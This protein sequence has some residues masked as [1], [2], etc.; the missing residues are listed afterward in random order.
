MEGETIAFTHQGLALYGD[1]G[2]LYGIEAGLE[3]IWSV[4]MTEFWNA[5]PG[6]YLQGEVFEDFTVIYQGPYAPLTRAD[7]FERTVAC[8]VLLD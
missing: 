1:T 4:D 5:N 6:N 8:L 7:S 2:G 3:P